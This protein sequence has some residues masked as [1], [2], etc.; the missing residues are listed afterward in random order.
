MCQCLNQA[1]AFFLRW[2][3]YGT[4]AYKLSIDSFNW[5]NRAVT[6]A[7]VCRGAGIILIGEIGGQAEEDAADFIKVRT[8]P[9]CVVHL[10]RRSEPQDSLAALVQLLQLLKT[11]FGARGLAISSRSLTSAAIDTSLLWMD[12]DVKVSGFQGCVG[13]ASSWIVHLCA[14]EWNHKAHC[15]LHCGVDSSSWAQDGACWR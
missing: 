13:R 9:A 4:A 8:L 14:G 10:T 1:R 3:A 5:A 15:L 6:G 12:E 2:S 7:T 11:F